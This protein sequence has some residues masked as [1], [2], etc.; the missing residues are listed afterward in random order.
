ADDLKP[1][2]AAFL[3]SVK[4]PETTDNLWAKFETYVNSGGHLLVMPGRDEMALEEYRTPTAQRILPAVFDKIV[5]VPGEKGVAWKFG[6]FKHPML[7]K[8]GDWDQAGVSFMKAPRTATKYW[9]VKTADGK[10]LNPQNVIVSYDLKNKE[11]PP[12]VL[13]RAVDRQKTAGRVLMFTTSFDDRS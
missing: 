11:F 12:A 3:L 2:R 10:P 5:T 4:R 6:N 9:S 1:Y 7:K 8:F 13:E